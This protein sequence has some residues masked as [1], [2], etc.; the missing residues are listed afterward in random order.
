MSVR[1][2]P[3]P[4]SHPLATPRVRKVIGVEISPDAVKDAGINAEI[5]DIANAEFFAGKAEKRLKHVLRSIPSLPPKTEEAPAVDGAAVTAAEATASKSGDVAV[6][7]EAKTNPDATVTAEATAND[8]TDAV[9]AAAAASSSAS[10]KPTVDTKDAP[11]VDGG[12]VT[13]AAT[14][15]ETAATSAP[16][17]GSS[18]S[19][20]V[21]IVDPPRPGLHK[22]C[23]KALLKCHALR[24]LVYVSCNP[25][26]ALPDDIVALCQPSVQTALQVSGGAGTRVLHGRTG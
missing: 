16:S 9:T 7:A 6:T 3:F 1:C 22:D 13:A 2:R 26:K 4:L 15:N 20:V 17:S 23:I 18:S 19:D 25:T 11:A 14:A 24:K 10:I 5:N 8:S 21:A 12:A